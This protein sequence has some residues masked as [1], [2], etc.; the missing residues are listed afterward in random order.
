MDNL[1]RREGRLARRMWRL[2]IIVR[3]KPVVAI[4]AI[5]PGEQAHA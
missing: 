1:L 2:L 4:S 3:R 5:H